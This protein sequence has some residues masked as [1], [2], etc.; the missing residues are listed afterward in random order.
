MENLNHHLKIWNLILKKW[1]YITTITTISIGIAYLFL[2]IS[3]PIYCANAS[4]KLEDRR[5][6]LSEL[7][8]IRNIYDRNSK[9]EAEK[10][11]LASRNV[12]GK[13]IT[14]LNYKISFFE[15]RPFRMINLY[16]ARPLDI[17]ILESGG[18]NENKMLFEFEPVNRKIFQLTYIWAGKK[19]IRKFLYN[20]KILLPG[21]LF[22]ILTPLKSI[23][24]RC[25]FKFNDETNLLKYI[26]EKL[27][28]DDNQ[29][30]NILKLQFSDPNPFLARDIL[31]AI[32][33]EYQKYDKS[34]R[35]APSK[36]TSLFIDTLLKKMAS[37]LSRSSSEIQNF[38]TAQGFSDI[39]SGT[40]E[41][42]T[43][44]SDL[45]K[46]KRQLSI[47]NL[48]NRAL[49]KSLSQ[50]ISADKLNYN[51]QGIQDPQ[52]IALL[53]HYN[54]LLQKKTEL[55]LFY[56]PEASPVMYVENQIGNIKQSIQSTLK[57]QEQQN[58]KLIAYFSHQIADLRKTMNSFPKKEKE[59]VQLQSRF[60]VNQKVYN[61]LSEKKLEA[62]ISAAAIISGIQIIDQATL[63][64]EPIYPI[65][66]QIY[67]DFG[68]GGVV[69]GLLLI[70]LQHKLNTRL[71]DT[72]FIKELS[73]LPII[74]YIRTDTKKRVLTSVLSIEAPRSHFSESIKALRINLNY[75]C[76]EHSSKVICITSGNSGEGKSFISLNLAASLSLIDKKVCMVAT[77]LRKSALHIDLSISN[78]QGLSN[79]LSGQ[80]TIS[81][82]CHKTFINNL[83]FIPSGPVPPNPSELLQHPR[84][85][86][87]MTELK[88]TY[89]YILLD[90]APVGLVSDTVPLLKISD[91][92]LFILRYGISKK[93][94][95]ALPE[96][97]LKEFRLSNIS[98]ILNGFEKDHFQQE[99][100]N[101]P[102][103]YSKDL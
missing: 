57:N 69:T 10:T 72:S 56:K 95:A 45:E 79:Y 96:K 40:K 68:L 75:L 18:K 94:S 52:L 13:A 67:T 38:K 35:S 86:E 50:P 99:Y 4:L 87:L 47:L 93:Y 27:M 23:P 100:Y 59:F 6:E 12:I 33:D 101:L 88:K 22:R 48:I 64:D 5:S 43:K 91:I 44:L 49:L 17:Q 70:F 14:A 90:S 36:Q 1:G 78:H 65:A 9:G 51:L 7:I 28:V 11:I 31:N 2:Y 84:M 102:D 24:Q 92:N 21:L 53:H 15:S 42:I 61:Y 26:L 73:S 41:V 37:V 39:S 89:D 29:N 80:Q 32:L 97:L 60:E 16:P 83:S 81:Q 58:G 54:S 85:E 63:P 30:T 25:H 82:I 74:G 71:Y 19:T 8:T 76:I 46:E 98:L 3:S 77:D 66:T 55:L 20:S 103:N 34:Q 62:G